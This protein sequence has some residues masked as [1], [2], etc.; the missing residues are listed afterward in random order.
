[1]WGRGA[2]LAGT[3]VSGTVTARLTQPSWRRYG[4]LERILPAAQGFQEAVDT[5][6][7]WLSATERQLAQ[8]WRDR[9][10][11]V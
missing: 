4:C 5:F 6:Q 1:M 3:L 11:V 8:L 10:S 9:K 7:E 2:L